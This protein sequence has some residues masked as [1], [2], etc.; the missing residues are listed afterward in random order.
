M[1]IGFDISQ[2]GNAKAG[3]G[4]FAD[5]LIK[6][7]VEYDRE[8]EYLLYS[9]FGTTYFDPGHAKN[10]RRFSESNCTHLLDDFTHQESLNFWN[11]LKHI[12]E[13][14]L[15]NPQIVHANNFSCPNLANASVIYTLYDVSFLDHPDFSSEEN[16]WSCFNG[17]FN[18]ALYADFIIAI[19]DYSR[20]R[21]LEVFPHFPPERVCVIYLGSRFE[22]LGTEKPVSN[23][24]P[25][26][27]WLCVGTLEP[28][29]NLRTIL[30]AYRQ[31]IDTYSD[32]KP[33]VLAGGQGWLEDDLEQF[34][35]NLG[36]SKSVLKLGYV[37]DSTLRWLYKNCW[38]FAYPSIYEGF[39]LPVL[40]AM[41]LGAAVITS[42]TTSLPEV[43]GDA[44]LYVNPT[45][46]AELVEKFAMLRD[47]ELRSKLKTLGRTRSQ[48]F[49]WSKTASEVLEVYEKV[50]HMN[51]V[52]FP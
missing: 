36:L 16:R 12:D 33:L 46:Q 35:D 4:Y 51:S 2:T 18:A 9:A 25:D 37:D 3:C 45:N 8:N 44:V 13:T 43:G 42:N 5:N 34:I 20:K 47:G 32:S 38:A 49:S 6:K 41:S 48:N 50:L 7:L 30:Y 15:G 17:V 21:F 22:E 26:Q 24:T 52:C 19:S 28:R 31:Y 23:L 14:R 27:F 1:K 11:N 10:T 29:K 39:G 40:E